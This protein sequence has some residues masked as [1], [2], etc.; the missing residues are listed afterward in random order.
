[1]IKRLVAICL[2]TLTFNAQAV[3]P[4]EVQQLAPNVYA[5]VGEMEQR[6]DSNLANNAT[7]GVIV[8]EA[9]VVLVDPGGS[10]LGARQ[11]DET[12]KSITGKPVILV[13]N[14]G[15]QDHR[16]LGNGYFKQKGAKVIAAEA[17][18]AD[19]KARLQNQM[20][21]LQNLLSEESLKGTEA[22]YADKTF[23]EKHSLQIGSVALKLLHV[24][25]AHTPGDTLV[26][27]PKQQI[28]FAGD[29]VYV[30][31]MLGVGS[32]SNSRLWVEAFDTL[33]A[34]QPKWVVP[35][36]GH[37]VTLEKAKAQTYDYLVFLREAVATMLDEG[38]GMERVG[39]ID[40]SRFSHLKVYEQIKGRNAQQVYSEMEW[41]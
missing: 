9:G 39:E 25:P 19:H 12:I 28:V 11:I 30:E 7:F 17:A 14:S 37:A 36:H 3:I 32:M 18:V 23:S 24:G 6:S 13:I 8:T 16:W 4:L 41:E 29:V 34:L 35:G 22:V 15:G 20:L 33:S 38:I 10:Y 21:A 40:Q 31:R 1:M 5:L 2:F 26:W 27:L